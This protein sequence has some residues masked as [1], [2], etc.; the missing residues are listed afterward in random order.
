MGA[1]RS[2]K[3]ENAYIWRCYL[4]IL[5]PYHYTSSITSKVTNISLGKVNENQKIQ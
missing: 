3:G 1:K 5:F 2:I 4:L